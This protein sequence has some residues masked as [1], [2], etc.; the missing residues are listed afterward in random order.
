M[1]GSH[2]ASRVRRPP[3][4]STRRDR[5]G[6]SARWPS[7]FSR[8]RRPPS[9]LAGHSMGGRIA[10][11]IV[12][13]APQ[14]VQRL[15]L[16]D[17]GWRPLP[18]GSAGEKERAGRY[19]LLATARQRGH[20]RHGPRL[21]PADGA[22][23]APFRCPPYGCDSRHD[24]PADAG[25][26]RGADRSTRRAAGCRRGIAQHRLSDAR[27]LRPAGRVEPARPAR[28][29]RSDD[30]QA[31]ILWQSTT[32]VTCRRWKRPSRWPRRCSGGFAL[33]LRRASRSADGRADRPRGVCP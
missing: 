31:R 2:C 11:E 15:A 9:P 27:A 23:R 20:A 4:R 5:T 17:T 26:I 1:G 24:R 22:S 32:A 21:G 19:A 18:A 12:R 10:L 14:R 28:G 16:L 8:R 6:R 3:A 29:D 33:R 13:R 30:R 25:S 7:A